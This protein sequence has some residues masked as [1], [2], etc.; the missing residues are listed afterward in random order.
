MCGVIGEVLSSRCRAVLEGSLLRVCDRVESV[1]P[2]RA[3]ISPKTLYTLVSTNESG[4]KAKKRKVKWRS[5]GREGSVWRR[6][7]ARRR[8]GSVRVRRWRRDLGGN[9]GLLYT[10]LF[11]TVYS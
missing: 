4:E 1:S 10:G 5:S 2:T 9:V 7:T 8:T 6:A 11:F 3:D